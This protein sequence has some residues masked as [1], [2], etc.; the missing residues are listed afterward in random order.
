MEESLTT[1]YLKNSMLNMESK[2]FLTPKTPQKYYVVEWKN[3]TIK[4]M[5]RVIM[6]AKKLS[7]Q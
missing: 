4:E 5:V 2:R 3:R 6:N 7:H 1:N